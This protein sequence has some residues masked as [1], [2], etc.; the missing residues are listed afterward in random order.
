MDGGPQQ[1]YFTTADREEQLHQL[2]AALSHLIEHLQRETNLAASAAPYEAALEQAHSLLSNGFT[3]EELLAL[4][5]GVPDLFE[6]YRY[7]E[8][9][10]PEEWDGMVR[11]G[12]LGVAIRTERGGGIAGHR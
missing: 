3:P 10:S 7:K 12:S 11:G 2:I 9:D 1:H 4:S 8:W 6:P 5:R